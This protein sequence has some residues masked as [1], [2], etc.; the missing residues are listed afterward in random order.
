MK[1]YSYWIQTFIERCPL[2][3]NERRYKSREYTERPE[4]WDKRNHLEE[5]YD[6]CDET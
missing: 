6:Y 5:V 1:K 2:C 4:E 3:G